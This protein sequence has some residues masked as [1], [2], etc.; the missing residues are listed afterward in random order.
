MT[1]F[2]K[3]V[4]LTVSPTSYC[5]GLQCAA[6]SWSCKSNPACSL[7]QGGE[8]GPSMEWSWSYHCHYFYRR[9]GSSY[10]IVTTTVASSVQCNSPSVRLVPEQTSSQTASGWMGLHTYRVIIIWYIA[11]QNARCKLG[12]YFLYQAPKNK[13]VT[14]TFYA[15]CMRC[16]VGAF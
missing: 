13:R 15:W 4:G 5:R 9:G 14:I 12:P 6:P 8:G 10:W 2:C 3:P 1:T 16:R 7:R 11:C